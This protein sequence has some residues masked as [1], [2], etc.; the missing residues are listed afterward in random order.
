MKRSGVARTP[1]R[2]GEKLAEKIEG[3]LDENRRLPDLVRSFFKAPSVAYIT[4]W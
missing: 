3:Q 4:D 2:N 1:L